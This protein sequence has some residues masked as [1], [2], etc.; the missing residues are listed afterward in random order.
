MDE[1]PGGSHRG[2][3]GQLGQI[4]AA[5]QA[6]ARQGQGG[7]LDVVV[8]QQR[9][10]GQQAVAKAAGPQRRDAGLV[11]RVEGLA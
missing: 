1:P 6:A 7:D 4:D 3:A 8:F 10:P 2:A 5:G 11:L 9:P